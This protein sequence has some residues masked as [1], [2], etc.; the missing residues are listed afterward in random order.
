MDLSNYEKI[1][2]LGKLLNL[3]EKELFRLASFS[4]IKEDT[5]IKLAFEI[6]NEIDFFIDSYIHRLKEI[7]LRLINLYSYKI[8][9]ELEKEETNILISQISIVV[10]GEG[11]GVFL[12]CPL[13]ENHN[14][15]NESKSNE[16][17]DELFELLK[18][19]KNEINKVIDEYAEIYNDVEHYE[20]IFKKEDNRYIYDDFVRQ[21]N[22]TYS[23][24]EQKENIY[25]ILNGPIGSLIIELLQ[26]KKN[27]SNEIIIIKIDANNALDNA[28]KIDISS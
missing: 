27:I 12:Q 19:M 21:I 18:E 1:N 4:I 15:V 8:Q 2:I 6:N 11:Y 9:E 13:I 22:S 25:K 23:I 5:K 10:D 24:K 17:I 3:K 7:S 20:L 16:L 26:T 14:V 28:Y